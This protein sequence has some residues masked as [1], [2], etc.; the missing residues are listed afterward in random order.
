MRP[1]DD[2]FFGPAPTSLSI[3]YWSGNSLVSGYIHKQIGSNR[4]IVSDGLHLKRVELTNDTQ[5]AQYCNGVAPPPNNDYGIIDGLATI[6]ANRSGTHYIWKLTSKLAYTTTGTVDR[7]KIGSATNGELVIPGV[8]ALTLRDLST[9]S[10]NYPINTNFTVY[11]R[12]ITPGS[13]VEATS[14]D[15]TVLTVSGLYLQGKFTTL[16]NPTITF[17]ETLDSAN[18]SPHTSTYQVHVN[19]TDTLVALTMAPDEAEVSRAFFGAVM[20]KTASSV[21][22]ASSDD[23]TNLRVF[24]GMVT[25]IFPTTGVKTITLTETLGVQTRSTIVTVTVS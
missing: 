25:G 22:T 23:G 8:G 3:R 7:W 13:Q 10:L 11:I 19:A 6:V 18:G 5:M 20:G 21:I 15:G 14:D 4:Y 16:G 2:S 24:G 12:G 1:L 17:V 9:S